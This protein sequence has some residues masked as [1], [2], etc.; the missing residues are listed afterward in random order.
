M[1]IDNLMHIHDCVDIAGLTDD[2]INVNFSII[3]GD[4]RRI[5][6]M[7]LCEFGDA[8]DTQDMIDDIEELIPFA[9]VVGN[10][11]YLFV[12]NCD[13]MPEDFEIN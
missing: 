5:A 4:E 1:N 11:T 7:L 2:L 8:Y 13:T 6:D 3:L 10:G 9:S 12:L